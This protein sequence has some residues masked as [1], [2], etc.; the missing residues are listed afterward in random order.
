MRK[1]LGAAALCCMMAASDA[2]PVRKGRTLSTAPHFHVNGLAMTSV[3]LMDADGQGVTHHE[4]SH[5]EELA[6]SVRREASAL[7]DGWTGF[8]PT[9]PSRT[10]TMALMKVSWLMYAGS[11]SYDPLSASTQALDPLMASGMSFLKNGTTAASDY[12]AA[13]TMI[14]KIAAEMGAATRL[15]TANPFFAPLTGTPAA[16]FLP[17]MVAA[18]W[19][20]LP[21]AGAAV[22]SNVL[23]FRGMVNVFDLTEV[24]M[25]LAPYVVSKNT[26]KMKDAWVN[27]AGLVWGEQQRTNELRNRT[28]DDETMRHQSI[29][30]TAAVYSRSA[31]T[32]PLS[33]TGLWPAIWPVIDS[34]VGTSARAKLAPIMTGHSLGGA[35]AAAGSAYMRKKGVTIPAVTF[36]SVGIG[37]WVRGMTSGYIHDQVDTTQAQPQITEYVHPLDYDGHTHDVDIGQQCFVGKDT[38]LPQNMERTAGV[39]GKIYGLTASLPARLRAG[40]ALQAQFA[41]LMAQATAADALLKAAG[42]PET[43]VRTVQGQSSLV[44]GFLRPFTTEEKLLAAA[45]VQCGYLTHSEMSYFYRLDDELLADGSTKSGCSMLKGIPIGDPVCTWNEPDVIVESDDYW[46][47]GYAITL[48]VFASLAG[49]LLILALVYCV[50]KGQHSTGEPIADDAEPKDLE[51]GSAEKEMEVVEEQ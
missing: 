51:E 28:F 38:T 23:A 4:L 1:T 39:C 18:T 24:S 48:V 19:T 32:S 25:M 50:V 34:F 14:K 11:W 46:W 16:P 5:N 22:P 7:A 13:E 30:A 35:R 17:F 26:R 31:T 8:D 9:K 41:A 20:A 36:A 15:S 10:R 45:A 33:S 3:Y 37:C 43:H 42:K 2:L 21:T 49:V 44:S 47:S 27:D 6:Q 29:F 12:Y 40:A